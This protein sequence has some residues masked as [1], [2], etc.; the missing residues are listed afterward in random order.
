MGLIKNK[1]HLFGVDGQVAFTFHEV[2]QLLNRGDDDFVVI[3]LQVALEPGGAIGAIDAI[4]R[5]ALVL[6]HRLIVEIFAV[7]H[8]KDFINKIEL[9]RQARRFKAG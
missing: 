5:K 1:D 7:N 9:G 2:G 8:K 3:F 6:F 4:G